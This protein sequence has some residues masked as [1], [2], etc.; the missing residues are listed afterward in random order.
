MFSEQQINIAKTDVKQINIAQKNGII[1]FT[2]ETP[3][4]AIQHAIQLMLLFVH[5]TFHNYFI[6]SYHILNSFIVY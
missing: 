4:M 1:W 6:C 5:N 2:V 3:D